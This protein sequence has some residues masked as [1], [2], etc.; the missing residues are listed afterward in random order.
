VEHTEIALRA[1]LDT[2]GAFDKKNHWKIPI[3][4]S[5]Q[6][7]NGCTIC[8]WVGPMLGSRIIM[9]TL[10]GESLKGFVSGCSLGWGVGV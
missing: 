5:E 7:E 4:A 9:A 2:E 1:L 10:A 6:H 3:K 8:R